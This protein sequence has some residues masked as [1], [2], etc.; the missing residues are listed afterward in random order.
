MNRLMKQQILADYKEVLSSEAGRR[1]LGGIFDAAH[2]NEPIGWPGDERTAGYDA[3]RRDLALRVAN[4]LREIDP[5]APA[6]CD[7][8]W[9]EMKKTFERSEED[10]GDGDDADGTD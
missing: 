3:G 9:A 10:G 5:L 8:A 6:L 7:V 2:L 1:V 4:T